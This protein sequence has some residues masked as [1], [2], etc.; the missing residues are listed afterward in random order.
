MLRVRTSN[1]A[2]VVATTCGTWLRY[3]AGNSSFYLLKVVYQSQVAC[4]AGFA[5]F[6]VYC[7]ETGS[8]PFFNAS[9]TRSRMIRNFSNPLS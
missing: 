5:K 9:D 3:S 8:H 1:S 6:L 4:K 2:L 7:N